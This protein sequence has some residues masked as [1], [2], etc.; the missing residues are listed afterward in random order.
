MI[1]V[2]LIFLAVISTVVWGQSATDDERERYGLG[3]KDQG[4]R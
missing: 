3:P 2:F 4:R 1:I